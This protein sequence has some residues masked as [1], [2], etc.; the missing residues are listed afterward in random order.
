MF[1]QHKWRTINSL[2][3]NEQPWQL[4]RGEKIWGEK[5]PF[6]LVTQRCQ[7]CGELQNVKLEGWIEAEAFFLCQ[8]E[9]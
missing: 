1:H 2:Q 7:K 5:N 9:Q 3:V 8:I 6:T 4:W